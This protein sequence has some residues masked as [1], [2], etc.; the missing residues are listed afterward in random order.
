MTDITNGNF[1]S[2]NLTGWTPY[3]DSGCTVE[4]VAGASYDG[5]YG[6]KL[7]AQSNISNP[8]TNYYASISQEIDFTDR[9]Y[10][11]FRF[12]IDNVSLGDGENSP[13]VYVRAVIHNEEYTIEYTLYEDYFYS[14]DIP[15]GWQNIVFYV[16]NISGTLIFTFEEYARYSIALS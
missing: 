4:V 10:F 6:C 13:H 9:K 14:G 8:N 5:S 15:S 2:G 16:G 1:E 3:T 7:Y 12:K 11:G